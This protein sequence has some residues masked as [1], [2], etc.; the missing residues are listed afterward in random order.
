MA[1]TSQAADPLEQQAG[2]TSS[3]NAQLPNVPTTS[4]C[5]TEYEESLMNM[6]EVLPTVD[7]RQRAVTAN[8]GHMIEYE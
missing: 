1:D 3:G 8:H 7:A 5:M 4:G 6:A 2:M